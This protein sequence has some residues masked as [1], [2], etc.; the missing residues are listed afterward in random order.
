MILISFWIRRDAIRSANAAV[1]Y[2]R[3]G[4]FFLLAILFAFDLKIL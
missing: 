2:N 3:I 4:D 1:L